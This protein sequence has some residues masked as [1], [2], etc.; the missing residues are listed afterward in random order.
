[1]IDET[2][3]CFQHGNCIYAVDSYL[4]AKIMRATNIYQLPIK[5]EQIKGVT[6]VDDKI[7]VIMEIDEDYEGDYFIILNINEQYFGIC[8]DTIIG[9]KKIRDFEWIAQE[10]LRFPFYYKDNE[11]RI[12]HLNLELLKKEKHHD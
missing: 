12:L 9:E 1:M 6:V 11:T 5:E 3:F 7:A 10:N 2:Y 4:I 8:A